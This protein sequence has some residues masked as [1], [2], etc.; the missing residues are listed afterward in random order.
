M[1]VLVVDDEEDIGLMISMFL[2][3]EG[4]KTDFSLRVTPAKDMIIE[5]DYN[6]YFLDLNL[7]DGSGYDLI[8]LIRDKNKNSGIA[9]ISAYDSNPEIQKAMD[10]GADIFIKKPFTKNDIMQGVETLYRNR[11]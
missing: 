6:L 8:P 9:V 5:N 2:K 11:S 10:L 4:L 7:P 3:K 1:S